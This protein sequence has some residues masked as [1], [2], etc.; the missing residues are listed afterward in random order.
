[1]SDVK[2]IIHLVEEGTVVCEIGIRSGDSSREFLKKGCFVHMVDPWEGYEE[3]P[4]SY[5]YNFEEDYRLTLEMVKEFPDQYK[6]YRKKSEQVNNDVPSDLGFVY[7][8]GNHAYEYVKRD[9]ENYWLKIKAGGWMAGD[10]FSVIEVWKA[11]LKFYIPL[12]DR[13]RD[14]KLEIYDRNWA[15]QKI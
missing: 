13:N 11:V 7:I 4:D 12:Y 6:I 10:D 1:M 9:I 2:S 8:D 15:I 5:V 14:Y 3:Y